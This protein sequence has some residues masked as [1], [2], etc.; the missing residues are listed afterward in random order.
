ML[1]LGDLNL[2]EQLLL[3]SKN[4]ST[5]ISTLRSATKLD[6][7][8]SLFLEAVC[9]CPSLPPLQAIPGLI[10]EKLHQRGSLTRLSHGIEQFLL[11][12][13][14]LMHSDYSWSLGGHGGYGRCRID[15]LAGFGGRDLGL[16]A[17]PGSDQTLALALYSEIM[18]NGA[19]GIQCGTRD[20]TSITHMQGQCLTPGI[21]SPAPLSGVLVLTLSLG[22]HPVR[23]AG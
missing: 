14:G 12:E 15:T 18:P 7:A 23:K 11:S 6:P 10:S 17:T 13:F 16:E 4:S 9:W 8:S 5:L 1:S 3:R 21:F 2:E 19:E 20:R 22:A